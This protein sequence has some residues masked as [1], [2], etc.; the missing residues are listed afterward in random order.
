VADELIAT[1]SETGVMGSVNGKNLPLEEGSLDTDFR[2]DSRITYPSP[3]MED[4]MLAGS[5]RNGEEG[6]FRR[7]L[8]FIAGPLP[9]RRGARDVGQPF[10]NASLP[11]PRKRGL[12]R[13]GDNAKL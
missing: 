12:G 1:A 13:T 4:R 10:C 2:E 8:R 7:T 3:R 11:V 6:L 9:G 5:W